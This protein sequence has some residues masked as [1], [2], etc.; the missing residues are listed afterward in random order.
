MELQHGA[1][2]ATAAKGIAPL[3]AIH[4][5]EVSPGKYLTIN[6][7]IGLFLLISF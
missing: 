3:L 6:R 4:L 5:I 7:F 1:S 2:L